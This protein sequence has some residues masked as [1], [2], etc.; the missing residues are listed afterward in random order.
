[1]KR[2]KRRPVYLQDPGERPP[3]LLVAAG[4]FFATLLMIGLLSI[5]LGPCIGG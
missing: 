1:M 2:K 5:M 3:D 4:I